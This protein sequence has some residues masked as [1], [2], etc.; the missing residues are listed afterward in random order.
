MGKSVVSNTIRHFR[1]ALLKQ[2]KEALEEVCKFSS[3][4]SAKAMKILISLTRAMMETVILTFFDIFSYC[5]HLFLNFK[6]FSTQ[7]LLHLFGK[8][9]F[10]SVYQ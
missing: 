9:E 1:L 4:R 7:S 2:A 6:I 3:L 8:S 10:I 5:D